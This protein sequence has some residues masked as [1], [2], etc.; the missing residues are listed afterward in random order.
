MPPSPQDDHPAVQRYTHQPATARV[1]DRVA[2]G[3]YATGQ[4]VF[5]TPK[6]FVIDFFQGITRPYAVV[7]RVI[8]APSTMGEFCSAIRTAL[9]TYRKRFGEPPTLPP[10]PS[11]RPT[12]QEIYENFKLPEELLSGSYANSVMIG[13]SPSEFFFD[14]IT[15]FYPTS[16]VSSRVFVAAASMPRFLVTLENSVRQHQQRIAARQQSA[17]D[18]NQPPQQGPSPGGQPPGQAP[19][20]SQQPPSSG[21]DPW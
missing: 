15:G 10:P 21:N 17:Q 9:E 2:R 14:F 18:P 11:S 4:L 12:L 1:P 20:S 8:L 19:G 7:A 6:E 13:H 16:A 3:V 5:D